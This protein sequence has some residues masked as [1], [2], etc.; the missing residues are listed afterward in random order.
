MVQINSYE[1]V[2]GLGW[3]FWMV[4][5]VLFYLSNPSEEHAYVVHFNNSLW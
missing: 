2:G 5:F 3:V 4:V 1:F